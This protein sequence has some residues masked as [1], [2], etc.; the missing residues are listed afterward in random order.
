MLKLIA[1]EL[2][3]NKLKW[4]VKGVAIANL[5]IIGFLWLM[6]YTEELDGTTIFP[7]YTEAFVVIGTLVRATLIIFAGVLIA[8]IIIDEYK[9][10]TI[11]VLFTYPIHRTRL[12][13]AKIIVIS[14][15]TFLGVVVSNIIVA[16]GFFTLNHFFHYIIEPLTMEIVAKQFISM[17]VY[18]VA[19]AGMGLIPLY[20]GMRS[21]SIP[22]TIVS[23]ILIVAVFN[24]TNQGFSLSSIL[25]IPLAAAA[26]GFL[27]AIFA[28]RNVERTDIV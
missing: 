16:A 20:F 23:S 9:N 11:S 22:A 13:I 19:A 5:V 17:L 21:K 12:M 25:A 7:D 28:I 8:N 1:L 18:A 6:A 15:V 10:K 3:K 24:S 26:V 2:K 14:G 4:Y 27:I